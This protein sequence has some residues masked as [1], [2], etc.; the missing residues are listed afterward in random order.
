MSRMAISNLEELQNAKR[1]L[2]EDGVLII[3]K[4]KEQGGYVRNHKLKMVANVAF[5]DYDNK[6]SILSNIGSEIKSTIFDKNG[7]STSK[8]SA[9][10]TLGISFAAKYL[11]SKYS[12]K[13]IGQLFSLFKKS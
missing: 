3:D 9:I 12:I 1:I 7:F 11:I 4:L 2:K 10:A 5:P 6:K 8:V 13:G